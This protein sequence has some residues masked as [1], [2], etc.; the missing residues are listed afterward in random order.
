MEGLGY[1][2]TTWKPIKIT[3]INVGKYTIHG[4]LWVMLMYSVGGHWRILSVSIHA[5]G[6]STS[7]MGNPTMVSRAREPSREKRDVFF[8]GVGPDDDDD[9]D[10]DEDEDNDTVMASTLIVPHE[11][12]WFPADGI[13][14]FFKHPILRDKDLYPRKLTTGYPKWWF[15]K[16]WFLLLEIKIWRDFMFFC[17]FGLMIISTH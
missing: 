16:R 1:I 6:V 7:G 3:Y 11:S 8:E 14:F 10:D 17:L 13:L 12:H 15:W 2:Y 4:I 5:R 9:D